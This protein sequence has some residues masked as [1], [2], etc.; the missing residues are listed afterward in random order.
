MTLAPEGNTG[1]YF[2]VQTRDAWRR[3]WLEIWSPAPLHL[4]G[5]HLPKLGASVT[6]ANDRGRFT[7]RETDIASADGQLLEKITF[8]NPGP[9]SRTDLELTAYAQDH[10]AM[11]AK[12]AVDYGVRVEHQRWLIACAS[13]LDPGSSG[14]PPRRDEPSSAAATASST[15]ISPWMSMHSAVT[16]SEP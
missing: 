13:P 4:N 16:R 8:T 10:W 3:E 14:P 11:N 1:N 9:Y 15:T 12:F 6:V 2:G 5:T 7:F